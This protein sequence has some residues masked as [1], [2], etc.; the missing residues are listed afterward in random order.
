M[1]AQRCGVLSDWSAE[2]V[3][4]IIWFGC[5]GCRHKTEHNQHISIG[6]DLSIIASFPTG[7]LQSQI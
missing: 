1:G 4:G 2:D 7:L 3:G 5:Y 6:H